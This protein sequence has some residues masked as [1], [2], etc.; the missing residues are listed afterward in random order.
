MDRLLVVTSD[1][2]MLCSENTTQKNI[3]GMELAIQTLCRDWPG[4]E[5][6]SAYVAWPFNDIRSLL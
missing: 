6:A 4:L 1:S 3:E 2:N 5:Y